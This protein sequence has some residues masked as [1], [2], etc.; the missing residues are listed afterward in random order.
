[1]TQPAAAD[2]GE[3]LLCW[4][5]AGARSC[6]RRQNSGLSSKRGTARR[7]VL[8]AERV[9]GQRCR[10]STLS[11]AIPLEHQCLQ[12]IRSVGDE[13]DHV[14]DE[15]RRLLQTNESPRVEQIVVV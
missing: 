5:L 6:A 15:R 14:R 9:G 2:R 10:D 8:R 12:S 3:V 7:Y 1:M 4:H 13:S 11:I